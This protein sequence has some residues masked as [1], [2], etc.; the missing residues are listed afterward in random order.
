MIQLTQPEVLSI[1]KETLTSGDISLVNIEKR[2]SY[3][4][5]IDYI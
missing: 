4:R 2:I 1:F 5:L 3:G